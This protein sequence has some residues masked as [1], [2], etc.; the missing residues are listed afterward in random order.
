MDNCQQEEQ[1]EAAS[2]DLVIAVALLHVNF[3]AYFLVG[4]PA[5]FVVTWLN[6]GKNE[7]PYE[8][9]QDIESPAD[10]GLDIEGYLRIP[11]VGAESTDPWYSC[12]C[13]EVCQ[14]SIDKQANEP[15]TKKLESVFLNHLRGL[16][17]H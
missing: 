8:N 12:E 2:R 15:K 13:P 3:W 11:V 5:E 6:E 9:E 10:R 1:E 16:T 17:F 7:K 4:V 14:N